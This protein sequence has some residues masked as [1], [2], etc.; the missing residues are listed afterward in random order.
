MHEMWYEIT[1]YQLTG[2]AN[3]ALT[4]KRQENTLECIHDYTI[5]SKIFLKPSKGQIIASNKDLTLCSN[6][7]SLWVWAWPMKEGFIW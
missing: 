6:E 2:Y 4:K 5:F 7:G 1:G 3:M